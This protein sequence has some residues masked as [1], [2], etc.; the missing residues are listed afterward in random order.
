MQD[1]AGSRGGLSVF[2]NVPQRHFRYAVGCSVPHI[3]GRAFGD[4][5]PPPE[6]AQSRRSVRSSAF[7]GSRWRS[8]GAKADTDDAKRTPDGSPTRDCTYVAAWLSRW[9]ARTDLSARRFSALAV[10]EALGLRTR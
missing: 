2:A 8:V 10:A 6:R 4:T 5:W 3:L 7:A 1:F 9:T